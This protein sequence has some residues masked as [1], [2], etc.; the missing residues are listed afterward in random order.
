MVLLSGKSVSQ[1]KKDEARQRSDEYFSLYGRKPLLAV[2]LIGSDPSSQSYVASKRK[3]CEYCNIDHRDC[4]FDSDISE[5]QLLG[6]IDSLNKDEGVDGILVQL[7]LPSHIDEHKVILAI[8]PSKDVDGFHPFNI[9]S[10]LLGYP[11]LVP[12]TPKGVLQLLDSYGIST[13]SMDA[14]ILGRSN[15]VGKPMGALLM[16]KDRNATVSTC[17]SLTSDI[18]P[19]IKRADLLISAMGKPELIK[20]SMVKKGAVVIDVGFTRVEDPSSPKGYRIAGDVDFEEV[21]EVAGAITPVPGGV[22]LMTVAMLMHNTL[23]AA[24]SARGVSI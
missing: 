1:A 4:F 2:V 16:Q 14:C 23:Q 20:A 19:F 15:I 9:G 18:V 17:H 6:F 11:S 10:L 3:A 22:G 24:F 13:A 8:D 21:K 12:C 5:S 7:P